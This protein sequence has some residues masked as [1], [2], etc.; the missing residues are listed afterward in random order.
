MTEM[1]DTLVRPRTLELYRGRIQP[2]IVRRVGGSDAMASASAETLEVDEWPTA[3]E[4]EPQVI[5]TAEGGILEIDAGYIVISDITP[6]G[7]LVGL[8]TQSELNGKR[9]RVL[10]NSVES[11]R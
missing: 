10:E 3:T 2:L 1:T 5:A 8:L 4:W 11:G 7:N 6:S 9:Y